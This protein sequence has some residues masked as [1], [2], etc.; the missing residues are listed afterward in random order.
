VLFICSFIKMP[1]GW[2]RNAQIA[3]LLL[4]LTANLI[5]GRNYYSIF[6]HQNTEM[7]AK[8]ISGYAKA[9]GNDQVAAVANT[10]SSYLSTYHAKYGPGWTFQTFDS[11]GGEISWRKWLDSCKAQYLV[12]CNPPMD[13][14]PDY[15]P[16]AQEYF[17]CVDSIYYGFN[18]SIYILKRDGAKCDSTPKPVFVSEM[19]DETIGRDTMRLHKLYV[20]PTGQTVYGVCDTLGAGPLFECISRPF[21]AHDLKITVSVDVYVDSLIPGGGIGLRFPGKGETGQNRQCTFGSAVEGVKGWH[22]VY[23]TARFWNVDLKNASAIVGDLDVGPHP[24]FKFKNYKVKVEPDNSVLYW[25]I[26]N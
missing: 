1:A 2:L 13:W 26:R 9:Y 24:C 21:E 11:I 25:L 23:L 22:S 16:I 7:F 6:Y 20:E 19:N 5:Y 14:A 12:L 8:H 3:A 15:L 4:V 10:E 17:K 18:T